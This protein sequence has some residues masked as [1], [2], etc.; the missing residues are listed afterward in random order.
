MFRM[1]C[2][3]EYKKNNTKIFRNVFFFAFYNGTTKVMFSG[4]V[5]KL[6]MN[7]T[8]FFVVCYQFESNKKISN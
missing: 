8:I 5:R 2:L 3:L 1:E 6:S 4:T 7:E